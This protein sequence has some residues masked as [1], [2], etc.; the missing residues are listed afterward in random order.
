MIFNQDRAIQ[1][2][3]IISLWILPGLST[4]ESLEFDISADTA[5]LPYRSSEA[6]DYPKQEDCSYPENN[7]LEVIKPAIKGK[8][9]GLLIMSNNPNVTTGAKSMFTPRK[10]PGNE[11]PDDDAIDYVITNWKSCVFDSDS[12]VYLVGVCHN[13]DSL[14]AFK[15]FVDSDSVEYKL[16]YNTETSEQ[17]PIT[18]HV[19]VLYVGDF[20]SGGENEVLLYIE[21]TGH[22]RKLI[23]LDFDNLDTRWIRSVASGVNPY[24]ARIFEQGDDSRIMFTTGN[25]ANGMSDSVYNDRFSFVSILDRNGEILVNQLGSYYGFRAPEFIESD[26]ED[27]YFITHYL[28]FETGDSAGSKSGEEYFLSRMDASG[29]ALKSVNVSGT[30][31]E[32]WLMPYG[33][34][35]QLRLFVRSTSK[36]VSMF[37]C[38]LNFIC[39]TGPLEKPMIYGGRCKLEG[40]SDSVFIF[41]DGLYDKDLNKLLQFPF[42]SGDFL[43]VEFDTL[44]NITAY[45]ISEY[46]HTHIGYIKRRTSLELVSVFYGQNRNSVLV[47][48][49]SLFVALVTTN[50][51]RRRSM[52]N[53]R[54][55][56]AQKVELEATHR[57]LKNAQA[58]LLAQGKFEQARDIAGGFAHEIR[59]ALSPARNALSKLVSGKKSSPDVNKTQKLAELT[60]RGVIRAL[61]LT[62][63]ISNYTK[64]ESQKNPEKVNLNSVVEEVL[65]VLERIVA[66]ANITIAYNPIDMPLVLANS[67]QYQIVIS[68]LVRNAI[69]AMA[70]S[71]EKLLKIE[72]V[73]SDHAIE[74]SVIDTG[75]GIPLETQERVFDFFYSTKPDTGTGIGL[76]LSRKIVE[77]Y[78]GSLTVACQESGP[79]TFTIRSPRAD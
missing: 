43:P 38:D 72:I 59:N 62:Q 23:L 31:T 5:Y 35:G 69:D 70:T 10:F 40:E 74:L 53:L 34:L 13:A 32:L 25:S 2:T 76:A 51:F 27:E 65:L 20:G 68:N 19:S 63:Q 7:V 15:L 73:K 61:E 33:D 37:D 60:N 77:L 12:S 28:D 66:E 46:L 56:S 41:A 78:D 22:F 67:D 55:I 50:I 4:A 24:T 57:D 8:Q 58:E 39:A 48:L 17:G 18:P 44:G 3:L 26:V 1:F 45:A 6:R 14:F 71:P 64:L 30:P 42:F 75:C 49:T 9:D 16:L 21:Y 11:V 29:K 47:F 79:T 54:L 52:I 36:S